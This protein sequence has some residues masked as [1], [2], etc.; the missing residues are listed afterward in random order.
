MLDILIRAQASCLL[1]QSKGKGQ[2]GPPDEHHHKTGV[3]LGFA[4]LCHVAAKLWKW[5]LPHSGVVLW[6]GM[7]NN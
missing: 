4:A 5:H 3:T 6:M 7:M 2:P 1:R